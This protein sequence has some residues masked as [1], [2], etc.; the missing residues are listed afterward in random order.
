[1]YKVLVVLMMTPWFVSAQFSVLSES[2]DDYAIGDLV[3]T[4]GV[5]NN[6]GLWTGLDAESCVVSGDEFV[7]ELNSGYVVDD[8]TTSTRAT[9]TWSDYNEGK[10]SFSASVLVPEE[11]TGGFIGFHDSLG[12]EMP[13]SISLLGDS[14][15]L[16]LDWE[17]FSYLE[18]TGITPG[19]HTILVTF[20]LD[21]LSSEFIVDGVSAGI[22]STSFGVTSGFGGVEFGAYAY[23]PFTGQQ[24][25][26]AYYIDD[27]NL[28]D[29]LSTIG[30]ETLNSSKLT[31]L[32]NP[33]NGSFTIDISTAEFT[34]AKLTLTDMTGIVVYSNIISNTGSL[35]SIDTLLAS[36]M[37]ILSLKDA[38]QQWSEK[39]IIK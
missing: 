9:W 24:P 17:A 35:H 11:S 20:D 22:M 5:S 23:N 15:M 29:E 34:R 33:S 21:N 26:G 2:F 25:P 16:F 3:S 14:T 27:L 37:Y 7:S 1:M 6:W 10:Y 31:V 36:G 32:P 18:V 38:E 39:I 4:V 12:L 8:G 19:W 28:V 13:H 30:M